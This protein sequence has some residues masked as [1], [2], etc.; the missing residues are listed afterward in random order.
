MAGPMEATFQGL[1]EA[2]PDAIIGVDPDGRI[3]LVNAQVE[4]LFGYE[5]EELLGQSLE[6]LVPDHARGTHPAQRQLYLADPRH[7]PMG[8]GKELAGRR[9]DGSE[10]PAEIS[11]SAIQ[12][13]DGLILSAAVRDV[14][15]RKKAEATF[16]GLLDAAPDAIVA[17]DTSGRITLVNV[18]A[19][20]LF[21]YD[22]DELLG[23]WVEILVP[24]YARSVHP[25]H[26]RSYF[27]E[28][29]TRPMGAGM[30][31]AGRRKDGSE[32]PAEISLS[33]IETEDGLLVSVAVRDVT[34]RLEAQAERERLRGQAER[35]RYESRLNQSQ[36]LESLGQLAGGI[37]H[38]FNNLLAVI[39]NYAVFVDE[40]LAACAASRDGQRLLA[41]KDDIEQIK[42]AAE[43]ATQLTRQLLAF[44]RRDVVQPQVLNLNDVVT[45]VEQLLRRTIGEH[46]ELVT[47]LAGDLHHIYADPGQIEQVLVNLV[48]NGRDAMGQGGTMTVDTLNV[49]VDRDFASSRPGLEPG[50][51]AGIRVSD[52]GSG[53]ERSIV[54]HAF[55][56]FFTT[57]PKGEGSG[58]G[59]ATVYGIVTQA[60]GDVRI[61]S[62]PGIGTTVRLLFPIT[63]DR[64]SPGTLSPET[65]ARRASET[66]LV[67]EDEDAMREV[68]RRILSRNG[69]DVLVARSGPE[70]LDVAQAH[71]GRIDLL[72]TDVVMPQMLGK[73]VA[74][75]IRILRPTI[76]VLF[77]SGYTQPVLASQGTLEEG[78]VLV[79][80]PFT[81]HAL[82]AKVYEVLESERSR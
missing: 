58:L 18:Q 12:T 14:T 22:R 35:E 29:H 80:K 57:K 1:L 25:S 10:F 38:D 15:D 52:T 76:R 40:D 74:E 36:R 7:R 59:L 51:Y 42:R 64:P 66:I 28:P 53:M 70:A 68:T 49:E 43:R 11:L 24:S 56:P 73:E 48:V 19:E 62:E 2:A 81:E 45:G 17:V 41:V 63:T 33:A 46:V 31:L 26:R 27:G 44:A 4:R 30:E 20:Q 55:E 47:S 78:V 16:R 67:V 60:G 65:R 32:F 69:H 5:R 8:A 82:L 6:V 9:K 71:G 13:P 79:E 21:G 72:L 3:V 54:E 34:D 23:T 75:R 61:Y 39:L 37:A 77:M 50:V